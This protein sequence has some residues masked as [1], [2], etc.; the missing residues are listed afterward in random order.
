[1]LKGTR[2]RRYSATV[3]PRAKLRRAGA[4]ARRSGLGLRC[5]LGTSL[6]EPRVLA[7][8]L[9]VLAIRRLAHVV[10]PFAVRALAYLDAEN[11]QRPRNT[12]IGYE[13]PTNDNVDEQ[14]VDRD[15]TEGA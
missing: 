2:A 14:G 15:S 6:E 7:L 1:M 13:P 8:E 12:N 11:A 4:H 10:A 9:S 5:R 3:C